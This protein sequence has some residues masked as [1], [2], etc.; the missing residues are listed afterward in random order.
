MHV[1]CMSSIADDRNVLCQ[2]PVVLLITQS[3]GR[4]LVTAGKSLEALGERRWLCSFTQWLA[5]QSL[6][7]SLTIQDTQQDERHT[8]P[9]LSAVHVKYLSIEI[10]TCH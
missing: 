8:S 10:E 4:T 2:V 3:S 6:S 5:A 7:P 1:I 9:S